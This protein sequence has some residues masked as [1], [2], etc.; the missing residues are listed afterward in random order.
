D[1]FG[2]TSTT[3]A[4]S[5]DQG[6][7]HWVEI[8]FAGGDKNVESVNIYWAW[9]GFQG[10]FMTSQQCLVQGWNGSAYVTQAV[11]A[12]SADDSLSIANLGSLTTSRVRIYQ[13]ANMGPPT[14]S[15]ILWLSEIEV[16][17][18]DP[19]VSGGLDSTAPQLGAINAGNLTANSA[20]VTW[21][22]DE[23]ATSQVEY[24]ITASYVSSTPLDVNLTMSHG[25]ELTGLQASTLYH[26]RVRSIDSV[27]NEAIGTD[28]TFTTPAAS[29]PN[30]PV[31][32]A[33]VSGDM[34]SSSVLITW[35]TDELATS[36]IEYGTSIS[37]GGFTSLDPTMV[38]N[39]S[40]TVGFLQASTTYHFRVKSRDAAGNEGMSADSTFTTLVDS[41]PA[42]ISNVQTSSITVSTVRV[43]WTTDE[44][45]NSQV[46]F[47]STTAYGS[48]TAQQ[49]SMVT[50]HNS[51]MT[52]LSPGTTYHFRVRSVDGSGNIALGSDQTVITAPAPDSIP[53]NPV[54]D[55]SAAPDSSNP[56]SVRLSWTAPGS[57][58][59]TGNGENV[60]S[61]DIRRLDGPI[62]SSNWDAGTQITP[63]QP[64][65]YGTLQSFIVSGLAEGQVY[66]FAMKSFD[67]Y[68]NESDLSNSVM[69][70]AAG[71]EAPQVVSTVV[72]S[73]AQSVTT[74][75]LPVS[76]YFLSAGY[77]FAFDTSQQMPA[78]VIEPGLSS[79]GTIQATRNL[80][81]GRNWYWRCRAVGDDSTHGLWSTVVEFFLPDTANIAPQPPTLFSPADGDSLPKLPVILT[82][83]N[84]SDANGDVL[85]YD[86]QLYNQ[87]Q[88][89]I[90]GSA[91][92]L[93]EGP[94]TTSWTIVGD[95][96]ARTTYSWR[97]RCSDGK[98][99]SPWMTWAN[100][101]LIS[102]ST[103]A[104]GNEVIDIIAYPNPVHFDRGETV[105]FNL[106]D[107]PVDLVIT[108]VA[109]GETVRLIESVSDNYVWDGRN[110]NGN[111]VAIG[112]YLWSIRGTEYYGKIVVKP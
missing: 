61:Y 19:L 89:I 41:I 112:I 106:P 102:N 105:T 69:T 82:V 27:G 111:R 78:P 24:G 50:N 93:P 71:I 32:T 35:T 37:Y 94:Q 52:N 84:G 99:Y 29:D 42:V 66:Y 47:G 51:T 91:S 87:S 21:S 33:V 79:G 75:C 101:F 103:T 95:F 77:E 58:D 34:S 13:P 54:Q 107:E 62:T 31:I 48:L 1:P 5:D 86:F 46:E 18:T 2:G 7:A 44:P 64:L 65:A 15:G 38:L 59:G 67:L 88:S 30:A 4:S 81:G 57:I 98:A 17:G 63:P 73:A 55:L 109:T 39:H 104:G 45:S 9:N 28:H 110:A 83:N 53:P 12:N 43:S 23:P 25:V 22:T 26:Y 3:W 90:V 16:M 14:Y 97:A 108:T 11:V 36:Q 10:R 70:Y 85:T 6:A 74:S 40:M 100:I 60:S 96:T 80:S 56:G 92:G 68:G 20:S 72:D 49:P 8:I 76:S